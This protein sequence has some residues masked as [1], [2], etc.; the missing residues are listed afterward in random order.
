M[1]YV[2]ANNTKYKDIEIAS[3][4]LEHY[5]NNNKKAAMEL[6][7]YFKNRKCFILGNGPSLNNIDLSSL[8]N[9][10]TITVNFFHLGNK[11]KSL[12]FESTVHCIGDSFCQSKMLT[13]YF[14][15]IKNLN[16][17]FIFHPSDTFLYDNN[18][19]KQ[20]EDIYLNIKNRFCI[21]NFID[22]ELSRNLGIG[23]HNFLNNY[24]KYCK[25]YRNVIPMIAML[26]A[27]KLGFMEIYIL[28][29][30]GGDIRNHFY[31]HFTC[32]DTLLKNKKDYQYPEEFFNCGFNQRNLEFKSKGI[33]C[34]NCNPNSKIEVFEKK[35]F[36]LI[37]LSNSKL[38]DSTPI[39]NKTIGSRLNKTHSASKYI[40]NLNKFYSLKNKFN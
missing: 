14:D 34:F 24:E 25:K 37:K 4:I 17:I 28:G 7:N 3:E 18:K 38:D 36:N 22:F 16:T 9:E 15:L 8:D 2:N 21:K 6:T 33:K 12:N 10:F 39:E 35:D 23:A 29:V 27:E 32:R 20:Y 13:Q 40:L 26:I 19:N 30:D 5:L 1:N 31:N 11:E